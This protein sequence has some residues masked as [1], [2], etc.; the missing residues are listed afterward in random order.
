M[1]HM[2]TPMKMSING[3]RILD[4]VIRCCYD[5]SRSTDRESLLR[6]SKSNVQSGGVDWTL[7]DMYNLVVVDDK[8]FVY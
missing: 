6:N 2:L 3:D 8:D 4:E 7:S 1:A 5:N